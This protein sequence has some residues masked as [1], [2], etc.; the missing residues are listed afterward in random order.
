M[1]EPSSFLGKDNRAPRAQ[2]AFRNGVDRA[3]ALRAALYC[4][5]QL[6]PLASPSGNQHQ[7]FLEHLPRHRDHAQLEVDV[8]A[9][10]RET[11]SGWTDC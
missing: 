7:D 1:I 11:V 4:L 6:A 10:A 8:A 9:L 3:A 2:E 5:D